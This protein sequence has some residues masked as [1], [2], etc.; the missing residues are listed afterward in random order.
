M[1][2]Y[3][4]GWPRYVPVA[5]R[6]RKAKRAMAKLVKKGMDIQPVQIEG[7]K[8][9]KTFW[10]QAWCEHMESLGDFASRL[11]RGRTYVRNGSVCH[12]AI[13]KGRVRAI[14]SG[15]E[16]YHIDVAIQ[17]LSKEKW[18]AVKSRCAGQV[19]TLLELLQGRISDQVMQVVTD[20]REGLFPL[21]KE[22]QLKCD[23]PD[24]ADMCKHLAAVLYGVGARL[25]E[26][27]ELLFL[28]RGVN[29]EELVETSADRAVSR[30]VGRKGRRRTLADSELGNVFSIEMS[31]EAAAP[32]QPVKPARRK[33]AAPRAAKKKASKKKAA[34]KKTAKKAAKKKAAAKKSAR[35]PKRPK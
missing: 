2:F 5:E 24:W 33:K 25:D 6:R 14:V 29:H 20:P 27:P 31:D 16:L 11:P 8:I 4:Y 22:I 17:V 18:S 21:S 34:P 12:L 13:E 3:D 7:R 1:G 30:A 26:R 35:K 32:T 28:L 10:G 9:A 19:G 23:C 15:S